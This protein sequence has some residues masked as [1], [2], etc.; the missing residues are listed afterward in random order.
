MDI[1]VQ[2]PQPCSSC[3]RSSPKRKA[4]SPHIG[5]T[6]IHMSGTERV[7]AELEFLQMGD[8]Y[9]HI[10]ALHGHVADSL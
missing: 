1:Y 5:T 2:L 3:P 8:G 6:E 7:E 10:N 9:Q 4:P